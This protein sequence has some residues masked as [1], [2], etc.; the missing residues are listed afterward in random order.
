MANTDFSEAEVREWW[1]E[2]LMDCPEGVLTRDKVM[3]VVLLNSVHQYFPLISEYCV[4]DLLKTVLGKNS[5]D[6]QRHK[7]IKISDRGI[8]SKFHDVR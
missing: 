4:L 1:R 3:A 7:K 2:F 5:F 8:V 6:K